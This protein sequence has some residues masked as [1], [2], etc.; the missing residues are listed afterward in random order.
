MVLNGKIQNVEL[1]YAG[2]EIFIT[3]TSGNLYN[4][5]QKVKVSLEKALE[6]NELFGIG[7]NAELKNISPQAPRALEA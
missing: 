5:R 1:V 4:E 3:E 6:Q 2:Q 7:M